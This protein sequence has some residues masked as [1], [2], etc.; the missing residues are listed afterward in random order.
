MI[1]TFYKAQ[2]LSVGK[3]LVEESQVS[4]II[5]YV[6]PVPPRSLI[7]PCACYVIC[8]KAS[9]PNTVCASKQIHP[10]KYVTLLC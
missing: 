9:K 3:S 7:Q 10:A 6:M 2:G 8:L 5:C 4:L 1:F